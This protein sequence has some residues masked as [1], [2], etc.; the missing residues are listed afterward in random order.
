MTGKNVAK[1]VYKKLF[2]FKTFLSTFKKNTLNM[3]LNNEL[4]LKRIIC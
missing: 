1:A 3:K 4:N 2:K